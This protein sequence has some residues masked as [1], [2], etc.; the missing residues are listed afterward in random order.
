MCHWTKLLQI[1]KGVIKKGYLPDIRC[2]IERSL[3]KIN[4]GNRR[5]AKEDEL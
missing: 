5:H 2:R 4:G 1:E 3:I